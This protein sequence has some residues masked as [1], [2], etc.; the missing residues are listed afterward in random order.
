VQK[1]IRTAGVIPD[2]AEA[3]IGIPHFQCSGSHCLYFPF[4]FSPNLQAGSGRVFRNRSERARGGQGRGEDRGLEAQPIW[5]HT[6]IYTT[7]TTIAG[8][9]AL[10]ELLP[11]L[12]RGR[13]MDGDQADAII[14]SVIDALDAVH[15]NAR[16]ANVGMV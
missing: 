6:L 11:D 10:L 3:A 16:L 15:P 7:P 12:R 9:L 2:E 4:V 5:L 8:V 1:D 13:V 14:I